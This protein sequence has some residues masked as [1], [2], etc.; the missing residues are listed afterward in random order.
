MW[1]RPSHIVLK[2]LDLDNSCHSLEAYI[3]GAEILGVICFSNIPFK[4]N[5]DCFGVLSKV[6]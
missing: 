6:L 5:A 3:L 2:K 4:S 1:N